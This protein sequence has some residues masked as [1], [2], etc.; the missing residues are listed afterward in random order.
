MTAHDLRDIDRILTSLDELGH[1]NTLRDQ[2]DAVLRAVENE[3][4][5]ADGYGRASHASVLRMTAD[6]RGRL[7]DVEISRAWQDRIPAEQLPGSLFTAY[8]TATQRALVQNMPARHAEPDKPAV[9]RVAVDHRRELTDDD[10]F[11]RVTEDLAAVDAKLAATER[12]IAAGPTAPQQEE[13]SSPYGYL[14]LHLRGSSPVSITGDANSLA[15]ANTD[16]LRR[17]VLGL[18]RTAGL[19]SES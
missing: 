1:L 10:W 8:V 18:F 12:M 16:Q 17:D 14:T 2:A 3:N 9:F 15:H 4:Q 19:A 11:T 6:P 5:P 13:I 7:V